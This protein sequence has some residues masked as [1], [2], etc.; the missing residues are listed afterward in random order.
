MNCESKGCKNE[1]TRLD[2]VMWDDRRGIPDPSTH[3]V[4]DDCFYG[5]GFLTIDERADIRRRIEAEE[6]VNY[7]A[8]QNE[9]VCCLGCGRPIRDVDINIVS[10]GDVVCKPCR[11]R[12]DKEKA[13]REAFV[14]RRNRI[15]A[16]RC[17]L[18]VAYR[19][20]EATF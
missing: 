14:A 3:N 10:N 5:W 4:C 18:C 13:E 19:K 17:E 12:K 8:H 11:E 20:H 1:A 9:Y 16:C 7:D 15:N 6:P 2:V